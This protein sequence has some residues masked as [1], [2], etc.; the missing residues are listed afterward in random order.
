MVTNF[1]VEQKGVL[2]V[3]SGQLHKKSILSRSKWEIADVK[4]AVTGPNSHIQIS[5]C[6][7]FLF[8]FRNVSSREKGSDLYDVKKEGQWSV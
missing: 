7:S 6:L 5:I 4:K 3:Q 1:L 2:P 8:C